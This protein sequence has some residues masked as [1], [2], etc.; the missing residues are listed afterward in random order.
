M[1]DQPKN[2]TIKRKS[3]SSWDE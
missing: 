2:R 3:P 1:V